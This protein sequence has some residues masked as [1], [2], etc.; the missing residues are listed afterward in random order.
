MFSNRKE[1]KTTNGKTTTVVAPG[2]SSI[3]GL[4]QIDSSHVAVVDG[5]NYCIYLV[6][7]EADSIIEL[8]GTCGYRGFVD[9]TSAKFDHP[10]NIE[11][12]KRNPGHL[13]VTD[14]F[15]QALRSVDVTSGT[16]STVI[17]T[18]FNNPAGLL[19]TRDVC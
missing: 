16:V 9:G 5:G 13:L 11:L 6:N 15:N 14:L 19:G 4:K 2:F 1:L 10:W 7:R 8:A 18:G 17:R 12:D 3:T